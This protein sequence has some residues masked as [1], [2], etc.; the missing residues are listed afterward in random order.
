MS[1]SEDLRSFLLADTAVAALVIDRIEQDKI[2]QEL[3]TDFPRVWYQRVGRASDKCLDGA[4]G[5]KQH[6]FDLEVIAESAESCESVA[7]AIWSRL[8]GYRGSFG[9]GQAL[10]VFV[11]DQDDD[12]VPRNASDLGLHIA[13]LSVAVWA[14]S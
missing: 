6:R 11:E 10:G 4:S 1:A 13:S 2:D 3:T 5:P 9:D 14:S 7:D 8:D 12:Y